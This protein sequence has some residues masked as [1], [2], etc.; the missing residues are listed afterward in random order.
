MLRSR[1]IRAK[2]IQ[3]ALVAGLVAGL[4]GCIGAPVVP[5]LG[6]LYTDIDAP[7]TLAGE[8][9]TRRGESTVTAWLGLIS[10]GDGGVK[11]AA[12][13]GGITQVKRV[14]YEYYNFIGIYQR[15]KTVAYGD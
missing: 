9:G 7:L 4:G 6:I 15:Y 2:A 5:P 13:A 12:A 3:L 1:S 10:T 11:A 8:T 14:D